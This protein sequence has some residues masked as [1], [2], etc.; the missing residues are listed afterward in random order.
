[1]NVADGVKAMYGNTSVSYNTAGGV[2]ALGSNTSSSYNIAE[3]YHG[4]Y[5]LTT[6]SYNIDIGNLG[7]AAESG[8]IRIGTS[9]TQTSA[10]C[11]HLWELGERQRGVCLL[12][13]Q[14]RGGGVLGTLQDR[15]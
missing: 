15:H 10:Y 11:R 3:G 6:G 8:I 7:V 12:H 9:G 4:G 14:T 5:D 2:N 13:R 1:V